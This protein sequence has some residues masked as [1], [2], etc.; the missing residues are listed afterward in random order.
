MP[1]ASLLDNPIWNALIT[2]QATIARGGMLARSFPYEVG[3]LSGTAEFTPASMKEM[4]S[5]VGS[6]GVIVLFLPGP[7]ETPQGWSMVREGPLVQMVQV[8]AQ[9]VT[10]VPAQIAPHLRRLT[11]A[12]APQMLEL[13]TLTEPGPFRIR[14]HQLGCFW[15]IFEG[16]RLLAMAGQRL[17]LPGMVEVSAVCTHPDARGRGY[18]NILIGLS[19]DEIRRRNATPFLHAWADNYNAI[20]IYERMGFVLRK[21]LYVVALRNEQG[22]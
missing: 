21:K 2:E 16:E 4:A 15:G 17:H 19:V 12:D 9:P 14:T 18:A 7:V 11:D 10:A 8:Q 1:D 20:R 13:A 6:G 5:A 3:P 22:A